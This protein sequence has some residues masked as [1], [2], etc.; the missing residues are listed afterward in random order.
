MKDPI[1]NHIN[2]N[3]EAFDGDLP[4]NML[5]DNIHKE[6]HPREQTRKWFL[7]KIAA[8]F[9]AMLGFGYILTN[10]KGMV[11]TNE[12]AEAYNT[13][14]DTMKRGVIRGGVWKDIGYY[15][16]NGTRTYDFHEHV[17]SYVGYRSVMSYLGRGETP[18]NLNV[19]YINSNG[20]NNAIRGY[21]GSLAFR[22]NEFKTIVL[23]DANGSTANLNVNGSNQTYTWSFG[24]EN[25]EYEVTDNPTTGKFSTYTI[26][27]YLER[28]GEFKKG[29]LYNGSHHVYDESGNLLKT[30]VYVNGVFDSYSYL[31]P[32]DNPGYYYEQYEEF[33]ENAFVSPFDEPLSTFGIDVD[34]AGYSNIRRYINDG[35]LPPKDAVKL[36]EMV[37]Y[38]E[39]DLPEPPDEHPFSI[40]TEVGACPWNLRNKLVQVC[41]KGKTVPK[42]DLPPS[43]LVFLLDVSGSMEDANK[44]PL[45]KQGFEL[46]VEELRPEDKVSIVVYAGAAGEVLS[47]TSGTDKKEILAAMNSLSAGGST[48]GGEGILLAYELAEKNFIKGGN[49]RIIL[50]TDGDF[51]VGVS[52]DDAL[53]ELIEEK[54]KSGVFLSVLGF[55][56]GNLQSSKME[57]LADNGN[58]NYAYIDNILEAKKVLV[59]EFGGTLFTIAK[60]VKLQLEFN[61]NEVGSYRLL[62]Y[63][64]RLLAPEDFADDTKDAGELGSGHT[65]VAFYE[66][67]PRGANK[68][69]TA[70][71]KYQ[72]L[73]LS[74]DQRAEKE[75]LTIKFRYKEPD[76]EKSKLITKTVANKVNKKP[77]T[78]FQFA[79]A[80][81]EFGLLIRMS[82]H[83]GNADF[84][85]LIARA[86][87][88]KGLDLNGYRSEFVKLAELGQFLWE[89]YQHYQEELTKLK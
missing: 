46:L 26:Q 47:P 54:R 82:E 5:W 69:E 36:E 88:N 87:H 8:V 43:N 3:R 19:G 50:A 84:E 45:L 85:K 15:L 66:V 56:E 37:N 25:N 10:N 53:V 39:Y 52:N 24:E 62:G 17:K 63:E 57:K 80:V 12:T 22:G 55:G 89:D 51:N 78:N 42:E 71:L 64:N 32:Y 77:S 23:A 83:R 30:E 31:S 41:I 74:D 6:L 21:D 33:E 59:T 72:Q 76:G 40:T 44:L 16:D 49:N 86:K 29:K 14:E 60:D 58:G 28:Q 7:L 4:D 27:G 1:I 20:Q 70:D 48:A 34:A 18:P 13:S 68:T 75:L 38:F 65:V 67:T 35:Y 9:V 61:P 81:A 2:E 73:M 79:S 11:E